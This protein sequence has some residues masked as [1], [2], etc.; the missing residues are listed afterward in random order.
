MKKNV[1]AVVVLVWA[2]AVLF[3]CTNTTTTDTNIS[4]TPVLD[5]IM[6]TGELV[7]GTAGS[8]PPLNMTTKD[9]VIIGLE[10]D[11][12]NDMAAK[13]GVKLRL[14]TMPFADLLPALEAGKVDMILSGMTIT[15]ERNLKVAFVGP[16]FVTGKGFLTKIKRIA[17]AQKA[18]EINS[19]DTKLTALQ[20]ST[21]QRF[22]AESIPKAMLVTVKN[23]DEAVN[24]VI[25]DKVDA[26]IA[27]QPICTLS[28]LRYPD[29]GLL[30]LSTPVT[31]E[32]IGIALPADDPLF[33]NW[34]ENFI[35][36]LKNSGELETLKAQ[37]FNHGSWLD[38]LP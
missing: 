8:M 26:M 14:E 34:V 2:L 1:I 6:H 22:V 16:Y 23:Y 38:R 12:A 18:S 36:K 19:P 25:E 37:W 35:N 27:D 7:V 29:K 3:A 28:V 20:G 4:T 10:I 17:S 15:P 13:M 9:G 33:I 32:P 24:L 31:Y 30:S 5:R 11:L 21:S